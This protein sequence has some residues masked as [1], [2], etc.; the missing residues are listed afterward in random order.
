MGNEKNITKRMKKKN[1]FNSV[2]GSAVQR[3]R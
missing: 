1:S 3:N 2:N